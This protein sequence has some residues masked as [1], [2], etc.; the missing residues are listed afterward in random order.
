MSRRCEKSAQPKK[1]KIMSKITHALAAAVVAAILLGTPAVVQIGS[2]AEL[3][4]AGS[5]L[6]KT[7]QAQLD[8]AIQ[9]TN[10]AFEKIKGDK[11]F[12]EAVKNKNSDMVKAFFIKAGAPKFITGIKFMAPEA[13]AKGIK[14]VVT[15]RCC[16]PEL[17]ITIRF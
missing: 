15:A 1:W 16:P 4:K 3:P 13:G 17:V 12:M 9:Q 11:A 2:A 14:I 10:M 6:P 8:A 5:T 7:D